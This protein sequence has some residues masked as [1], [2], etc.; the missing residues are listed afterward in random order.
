MGS[1]EQAIRE[2]VDTWHRATRAG[3]V[4]RVLRLMADDVVFLVPGRPPMRGK[5][6]FAKGLRTLLEHHRISSSSEI[7]E[8]TVFGDWACCWNR[9]DVTVTPLQAGQPNRRTGHTLSVL[10]KQS[11][12]AWVI[13]RDANML[14]PATGEA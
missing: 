13:F 10:R 2:L 6:E 9:L 4:D 5:D 14:A 7:Q 1:D 12:G 3:D 8:I 11:D